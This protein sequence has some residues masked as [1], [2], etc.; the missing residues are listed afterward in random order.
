M[1]REGA[2]GMSGCRGNVLGQCEPKLGSRVVR[3]WGKG[4]GQALSPRSAQGLNGEAAQGQGG[5]VPERPMSPES[6][7]GQCHFC[8]FLILE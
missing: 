8:C 4:R 1:Q 3:A 5:G 6:D 7:L 2:V